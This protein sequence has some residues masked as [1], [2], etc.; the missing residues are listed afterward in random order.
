MS[1]PT[2]PDVIERFR[3][4]HR[5][6]PVWG[7][8]HVILEAGNFRDK[9]CRWCAAHARE[10]GDSEGEALAETLLTMSQTQ[11]RRIADRA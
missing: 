2:V 10:I 3:S 7:A 8:L 4:Y 6:N 11:R 9:D 5:G 1:R